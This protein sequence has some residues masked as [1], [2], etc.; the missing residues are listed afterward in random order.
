MQTE[1]II[2]Y[3]GEMLDDSISYLQEVIKYNDNPYDMYNV[4]NGIGSYYSCS[5]SR[6]S[7]TD[8]T[9]TVKLFF[10]YYETLEQTNYVKKVIRNA[11]KENIEMLQTDY[12]KAHWIYNWIAENV[13][14]DKTQTY[15]SAYDGLQP[16]GTVCSGYA[17]LFSYMANELGL[18]CRYVGGTVDKKDIANHAWNIVKLND[19]WYCID[20]TWGDSIYGDKFFLKSKDTFNTLDYRYHDSVLYDNYINSGEIFATN[21]YCN[22]DISES[23]P[24]MPSVYNI[25]MSVFK[26]NKLAIKEKYHFMINNPDN[27]SICFISDDPCIAKVDTNGIVIGVNKGTT[28]ITAYNEELNFKQ[29]VEITVN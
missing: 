4:S 25:E 13:Y 29:S 27:I 26:Q 8:S 2:V 11:I 10:T 17:A 9:S 16:T 24:I 12:Q 14:Y 22:I 18:D 21:D 23:K 3:S 28:T 1:V 20:S 19:Q 5:L 15:Y 7:E 6:L